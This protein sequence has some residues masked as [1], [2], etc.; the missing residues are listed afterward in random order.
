MEIN[1]LNCCALSEIAGLESY[2]GDPEQ[3]VRD[4]CEELSFP[5]Y[6]PGGFKRVGTQLGEPG[7]HYVFTALVRGEDSYRGTYGN[8]LA[9]YIKKH[10]LGVVVQSPIMLNRQNYDDHYVRAWIWSPSPKGLKRWW[11]K[12]KEK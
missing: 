6:S 2:S 3:F 4:F 1:G 7:A 11:N 12:H 8:N 10:K 9:D 5:S